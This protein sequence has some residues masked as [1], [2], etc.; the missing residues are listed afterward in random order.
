MIRLAEYGDLNTIMD[1]YAIA[2]KYMADNG[3]ALQWPHTYPDREMLKKDI[4]KKQLFVCIK[5]NAIHGVFAFIIGPDK[6]YLNIENGSWKNDAPYG[7]I[8]RI[9]SDGIVKGVF[10]QCFDFCRDRISNLRIDTHQNNRIMQHLIEKNGFEK[11]GIVYI[12]DGTARIAY[13]YVSSK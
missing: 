10:S 12:Q 2:R 4:H 3:N 1:I 7:T 8:H 13:Q 5:N 6:T 11:C 9:A